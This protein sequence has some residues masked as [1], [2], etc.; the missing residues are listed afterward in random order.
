MRPAGRCGWRRAGTGRNSRPSGSTTPKTSGGHSSSDTGS[1]TAILSYPDVSELYWQA[2]GDGWIKPTDRAE[3]VVTLPEPLASSSDMLVY[4]H[5]PL[6]GMSEIVD[7]RTARFAATDFRP[8]SS[9]RS[10]SSGRPG[11]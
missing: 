7:G 10:G 4:G 6:S 1:A 11:S 5:G 9:W 8:G 3:V 2:I